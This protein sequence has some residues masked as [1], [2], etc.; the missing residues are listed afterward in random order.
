MVQSSCHAPV[1]P[2]SSSPCQVRYLWASLSHI[3]LN[4][5]L[6]DLFLR[7][8]SY[9]LTPQSCF[10]LFSVMSL[11]HKIRIKS[12]YLWFGLPKCK[13]LLW[14]WHPKVSLTNQSILQDTEPNLVPVMAP[15]VGECSMQARSNWDLE[16]AS[17][18]CCLPL[19]PGKQ[20]LRT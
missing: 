12:K 14:P 18:D 19:S 13:D 9:L 3:T 17:W 11:I 7:P 15:G 10:H 5:S 8:K 6:W 4:T 1:K 2:D 20:D 16:R